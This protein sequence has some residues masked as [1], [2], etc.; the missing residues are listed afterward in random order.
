MVCLLGVSRCG[1]RCTRSGTRLSNEAAEPQEY[2]Y[3]YGTICHH[4]Y[5]KTINEFY[6]TAHSHFQ[7][8]ELWSFEGEYAVADLEGLY[9][10]SLISEKIQGTAL[11]I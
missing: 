3:L 11:A 7:Q 4:V 6:S 1:S 5:F 2:S 9:E 8:L 10:V